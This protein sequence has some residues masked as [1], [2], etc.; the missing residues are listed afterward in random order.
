[1]LVGYH[2]SVAATGY[3]GSSVTFGV[4]SF[5]Y[6]S[7]VGLSAN[8]PVSGRI[9]EEGTLVVNII[10]AK[11]NSVVWQG[12]SSRELSRSPTPEKTQEMVSEVVNEILVN[13]P[14]KK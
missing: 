2:I 14:P 4:G 12:S 9:I 3:S 13:Y 1:M 10:D 5:G 6:G 11:K 8:V 7:G